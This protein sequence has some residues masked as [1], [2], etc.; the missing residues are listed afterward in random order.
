MRVNLSR[1]LLS[2]VAV[3]FIHG[4]CHAHSSFSRRYYIGGQIGASFMQTDIESRFTAFSIPFPGINQDTK[5]TKKNTSSSLV[6]EGIMGFRYL[7]RERFL[8]GFELAA[9]LEDHCTNPHFIHLNL[10]DLKIKIKKKYTLIPALYFGWVFAPC[11]NLFAKIGI[12]I[13]EFKVDFINMATL[14]DNPAQDFNASNRET[15][16]AFAPSIGLE[17]SICPL[18][19]LLITGAWE[20]YP[21][22]SSRFTEPNPA[23][24]S[25]F[26]AS[27]FEKVDACINIYTVKGGLLFKF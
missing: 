26:V 5:I 12:G 1:L 16:I 23:D 6:G 24:A 18:I 25:F 7:F 27:I 10:Q 8:L 2:I 3:L 13:T 22:I 11:W 19:S 14:F 9:N 17:Y 15:G 21:N 20:Y 4:A